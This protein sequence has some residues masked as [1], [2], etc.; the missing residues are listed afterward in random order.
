[1]HRYLILKILARLLTRKILLKRHLDRNPNN[2]E[3]DLEISKINYLV[4]RIKNLKQD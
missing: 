3:V 4:K 2:K 1:M